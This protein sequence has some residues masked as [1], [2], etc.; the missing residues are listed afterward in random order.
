[1]LKESKGIPKLI[2]AIESFENEVIKISSRCKVNLME[3]TKITQSRDF[4]I[5]KEFLKELDDEAEE[6]KY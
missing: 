4:K 6:V 5:T 1:V 2:F 3:R